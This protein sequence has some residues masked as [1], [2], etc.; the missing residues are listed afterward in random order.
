[1]CAIFALLALGA[2]GI[3]QVAKALGR[4]LKRVRKL[5]EEAEKLKSEYGRRTN[6]N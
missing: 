2:Y 1:M 4:R 5:Q 6:N 3:F